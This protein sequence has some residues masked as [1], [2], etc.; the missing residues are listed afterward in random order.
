MNRRDEH[1]LALAIAFVVAAWLAFSAV[2]GLAQPATAHGLVGSRAH[3]WLAR[4]C[5]AETGDAEVICA[6]QVHVL[7]RRAALRGTTVERMTRRYSQPLHGTHRRAWVQRLTTHGR[8]PAGFPR[9]ASW[10]RAQERFRA[11]HALVGD[12]LA[13]TYPDPCPE[14]LHFGGPAH[15]DGDG[16]TGFVECCEGTHELQRLWC[17]E[18]E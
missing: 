8:R 10:P 11:V 13:G 12:V 17:R 3:D 5:F 9:R 7:L 18:G 4:A 1:W 16:P 15:L 2:R 6:A 14:A